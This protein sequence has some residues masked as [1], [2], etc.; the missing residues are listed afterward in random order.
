MTVVTNIVGGDAGFRP[1]TTGYSIVGARAL[2]LGTITGLGTGGVAFGT[3]EASVVGVEAGGRTG[4]AGS[5]IS[6]AG[7]SLLVGGALDWA[8]AGYTAVRVV[9]APHVL[10]SVT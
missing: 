10:A 9:T 4:A 6:E 3:V 7:A 1:G 8:L 5:R 2:F